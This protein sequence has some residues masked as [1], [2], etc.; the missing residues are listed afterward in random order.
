MPET[1]RIN[2]IGDFVLL[3]CGLPGEGVVS[4]RVAAKRRHQDRMV[5]AH[6]CFRQCANTKGESKHKH[7]PSEEVEDLGLPECPPS[8]GE[9]MAEAVVET[10][11]PRLCASITLIFGRALSD[12]ATQHPCAS[13]CAISSAAMR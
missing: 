10:S 5:L 13:V 2:L 3:M 9:S 8:E 12:M 1:F 4:T 11:A 7:T 6:G